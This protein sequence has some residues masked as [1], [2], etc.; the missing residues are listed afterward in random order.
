MSEGEIARKN[1]LILIV[2]NLNKISSEEEIEH[3]IKSSMETSN[4]V[5]CFFKKEDG[6]H[7]GTCN[8]E[9]LNAAVSKSFVHQSK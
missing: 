9:C 2:R 6:R 8:V 1:C 3:D 4:V 5:E 7:V